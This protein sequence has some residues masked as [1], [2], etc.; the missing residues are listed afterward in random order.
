MRYGHAAATTSRRPRIRNGEGPALATDR[1]WADRLNLALGVSSTLLMLTL[2]LD[3]C[4][5]TLTAARGTLWTGLA[6]LLL[7]VLLPPRTAA[8]KDWLTVRHLLRTQRV[9]TDL[10]VGATLVGIADRRLC[11]RDAFGARAE[12]DP[13]VLAA[14]PFLWHEFD[15]AARRSHRSGLLRDVSALNVLAEE[16]DTAESRRLLQTA[17]LEP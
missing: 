11:L 6:I 13:R 7:T 10:L 9:R 3:A 16:I 2:V 1:R 5:G 8:G 12:V 15:R 17:G 14:N 4:A